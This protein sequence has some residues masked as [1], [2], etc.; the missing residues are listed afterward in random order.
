MS[1]RHAIPAA[2][3]LIGLV[4]TWWAGRDE[5]QQEGCHLGQC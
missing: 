1:W 5:P 4:G 2:V 3:L